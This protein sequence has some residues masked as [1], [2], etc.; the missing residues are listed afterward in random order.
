MTPKRD[1]FFCDVNFRSCSLFLFDVRDSVVH[2]LTFRYFSDRRPMEVSPTVN[3]V[4]VVV[5]AR[6]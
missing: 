2:I 1:A 3:I 4:V 6:E 5:V